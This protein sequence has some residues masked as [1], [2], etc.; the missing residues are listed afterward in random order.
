MKRESSLPSDSGA[1]T[2]SK[3]SLLGVCCHDCGKQHGESKG[4]DGENKAEA[5]MW[6]GQ[7]SVFMLVK[8]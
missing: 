2:N 3:Q 5:D 7:I 6:R 1:S 4:E 8:A